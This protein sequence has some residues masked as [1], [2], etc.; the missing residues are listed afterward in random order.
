[1]YLPEW[2]K[3]VPLMG[4]SPFFRKTVEGDILEA[5]CFMLSPTRHAVQIIIAK[6]IRQSEPMTVS[7]NRRSRFWIKKKRKRIGGNQERTVSGTRNPATVTINI[8]M[9]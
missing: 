4:D 3:I 6:K 5:V 8:G 9:F 1:M 2:S 7:Q